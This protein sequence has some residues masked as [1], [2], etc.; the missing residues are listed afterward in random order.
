M[1][2]IFDWGPLEKRAFYIK[3][4]HFLRSKKAFYN[5]KMQFIVSCE[6]MVL[7]IVKKRDLLVDKRHFV[8]KKGSI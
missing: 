8:T 7:L 2:E 1:F 6:I 3:K 5:E 4:R